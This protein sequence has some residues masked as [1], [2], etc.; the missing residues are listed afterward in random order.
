[1]VKKE[2]QNNMKNSISKKVGFFM[3]G[4]NQTDIENRC[5]SS[6]I[7]E[8]MSRFKKYKQYILIRVTAY[9]IAVLLFK[10]VLFSWF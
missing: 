5:I 4:L 6:F 9:T 8:L 3:S 10:E 1:M 7:R 2:I